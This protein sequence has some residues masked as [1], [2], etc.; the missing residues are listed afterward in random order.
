MTTLSLHGLQGQVLRLRGVV[1]RLGGFEQQGVLHHTVCVR[2]LELASSGEALSPD[3]WWFRLRQPWCEAG[4]QE[5][6]TI[7]VT[8][9]V[10]Q[11]S[12]GS[13]ERALP[14]GTSLR[15]RE[16]VLG[17]AGTVRDLVVQ[18]RAL[19]PSLQLQDLQEQLRRQALLR[20]EAEAE[21]QRLT[22]HRDALLADLERL[23]SQL[24][25]WKG[26]C[27]ILDPSLASTALPRALRGSGRCRGFHH[28]DQLLPLPRRRVAA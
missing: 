17:F 10:S 13:H 11:C 24:A 25:T 8:V 12:K 26:R 1:D 4:V 19:T 3:H 16:R 23:R 28:V 22:V 2:N 5:G 21:A 15:A 27:Q 6:D 20:Q 14:D 18:R 9:K 7:L